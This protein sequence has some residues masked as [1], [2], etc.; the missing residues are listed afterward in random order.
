VVFNVECRRGNGETQDMNRDSDLIAI[1]FIVGVLAAVLI[2]M[3]GF[4][5]VGAAAGFPMLIIA[6][7]LVGY[8]AYRGLKNSGSG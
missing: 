5:L 4:F 8:F 2:V 7:S 6:M 1:P 3:A